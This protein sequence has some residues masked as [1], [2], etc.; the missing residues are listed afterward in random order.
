MPSSFLGGSL[1][2][3]IGILLTPTVR[4]IIRYK[5]DIE[6]S[7][8][9][10]IIV[11]VIGLGIF[12][13]FSSSTTEDPNIQIAQEDPDTEESPQEP[14]TDTETQ[15]QLETDTDT[16]TQKQTEPSTELKTN[17]TNTQQEPQT[18]SA[19]LTIDRIETQAA[20]LYPTR[21]TVQNTGDVAVSPKFDMYVY[22]DQGTEV[23]T[24]SPT[25]NPYSSLNSKSEETEEIRIGICM[26]EEDGT[27]TLQVD[28]M[29][30]DFNSLDT[31]K[32]DFTISY[33]GSY[34]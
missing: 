24:G 1:V 16:E 27:Y 10:V 2:F 21:V 32:K 17:D 34:S 5:Y 29:D 28:L 14:I 31:E 19:D 11:A 8:G 9:V 3:L 13:A 22:D 12:G 30:D 15:D 18:K 7:K 6:F 23:C 20:N 4:E 26:M 33:W 25:V